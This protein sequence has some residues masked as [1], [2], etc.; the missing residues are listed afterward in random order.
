MTTRPRWIWAVPPGLAALV[1]APLLTGRGF[2]L[3]GDM[4][5]VPVQPWKDA[6]TGSDGGVPRAVPS[7]AW[8]SLATQVVPGDLLQKIVLLL[9]LAG[10]GWGVLR[11]V[12]DLPAPAALAAAV[13]FEWNPYVHERLGI[14]H[15]ALLCGYAA[16]PW[17]ALGARRVRDRGWRA[18]A[19][20]AL[21]AAV[22]A[23]SSPSGGVMA[24]LVV[25][26]VLLAGLATRRT[27]VGSVLLAG[28]VL[29]AVNLAWLL[30]GLLNGADQS[31][32][33]AG[34]EAFAA[35]ADTPI[36]LGG[37]LL[38]LGAFWKASIDPPERS[39]VVLAGL[40]LGLTCAALAGLV[41]GW[42][43]VDA[44][45]ALFA[46]LAVPAALTLALVWWLS[47][48]AGRPAMQWLITDV[49][50]GGLARDAQKWV[51]PFALLLAVGF[52]EAVG[53]LHG[54][55]RERPRGVPPSAAYAAALVPVLVLPS[56]AW[57]LLGHLRLATYPVEWTQVAALMDDAGAADDRVV[58]L[59]FT[60]YRRFDWAHE[61]ALLDPAP[62]FFPGQ[63]LVDDLLP[64]G[65]GREVA[66][67]AAD[68]ARIR[69]AVADGTLEATLHELGVRWVL[70]EHGT[71]GDTDWP[72][73]AGDVVHDG[74]E[75][76]LVDLG[77]GAAPVVSPH[78]ALFLLADALVAIGLAV[79][80][81]TMAILRLRRVYADRHRKSIA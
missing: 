75:L 21:P 54:R 61:R 78:R 47:T 17:C 73:G 76:T 27:G 11:L 57:G 36:G 71:P 33:A 26:G 2:G 50:G 34:A 41:C 77:P 55:L 74:P 70:I 79:A 8:V 30:P 32:D 4:V 65:E 38:T 81:A 5:F 16:L 7:D 35:R 68:A 13:L 9:V 49:P 6:W 37:S 62:R 20:V 53:W 18:L 10:S 28:V 44:D 14:G 1:V 24:G 40:A 60:I 58:A 63:V 12:R 52:G 64:L 56:L 29:V 69:Q 19:S 43:R 59:P 66:G 23:W 3:V 42:R 80:A 46:G 15:W 25:M 51:A 67:E 72:A 31:P 45:R 48:E 39:S 22:A